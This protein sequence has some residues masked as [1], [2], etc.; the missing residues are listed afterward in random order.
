MVNIDGYKTLATFNCKIKEFP[1][2]NITIKKYSVHYPKGFKVEPSCNGLKTHETC[3]DETDAYSYHRTKNAVYD[4]SRCVNWE[5]FITITFDPKKIDSMNFELCS[6]C[7]RQWLHNQRRYNSPGLKF[8]LVPEQH[9]SG[10]WHFHGVLA[11]T[12]NMKFTDSGIK[13]H[14]REVYNM[15]GFQYG[16]TTATNVGSINAVAKYVGKYITKSLCVLT[17]GRHRYFVSN[18]IKVPEAKYIT[19]PDNQTDWMN[20][21]NE[22][23]KQKGKKIVYCSPKQYTK[24]GIIYTTDY[25]EL[26]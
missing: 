19:L 14:G 2:G 16:F 6:S 21:I 13:Q 15:T 12:G 18:D 25:I 22:Y 24:D 17:S 5:R 8:L 20:V 23:A 7:V 10:A 11:N 1:N 9:K 26:Q 3:K 4:Y